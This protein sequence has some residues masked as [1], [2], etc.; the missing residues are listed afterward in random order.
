MDYKAAEGFEQRVEPR[1]LAAHFAALTD[2][3]KRRG[4]R[5]ELAPLLVLIALA[6]MCGADKPVEIAEWVS[7]RTEALKQALG[8]AWKRMPHASTYRRLLSAVI[9]IEEL[10]AQARHFIA[11]RSEPAQAVGQKE[12]KADAVKVKA[13]KVDQVLAIDG[14]SLRGTIPSGETRGLHLLAI[15]HVSQRAPRGADR[16]GAEGKRNL[17]RATPHQASRGAWP[18]GDR[19]CDAGTTQTLKADCAGRWRLSLDGQ[20]ESSQ[21]VRGFGHALCG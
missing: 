6:K 17:C 9:K 5:Y 16:R 18:D 4:K 11:A 1:S 12:V 15:Y 3:R 21:I 7:A 2:Q 8:L 20:K 19:R 10:E 14:K 13:G